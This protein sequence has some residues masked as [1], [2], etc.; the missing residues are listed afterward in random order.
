[1]ASNY[2]FHQLIRTTPLEK[3]FQADIHDLKKSG[4]VLQL[5]SKDQIPYTAHM[6]YAIS[7]NLSNSPHV[8]TNDASKSFALFYTLPTEPGHA[9]FLLP[10][11]GIAIELRGAVFISWD[12]RIQH[13][14]SRTVT[15]DVYSFFT[16]SRNDIGHYLRV[17]KS[18]KQQ[19]RL[20]TRPLQLG[21]KVYVRDTLKNM[22]GR[23]YN[24]PNAIIYPSYPMYRKATVVAIDRPNCIV[25]VLFI[26]ELEKLGEQLFATGQVCRF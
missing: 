7:K 15:G 9:W 26:G 8:D 14:C 22:V 25:S 21:E 4:N 20:P 17:Q 23:K 11:Y 2:S 19:S 1:M 12:G 6:T 5:C 16:S 18:F 24:D 10:D 3:S 13:H